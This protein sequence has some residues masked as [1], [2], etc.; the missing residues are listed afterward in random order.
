MAMPFFIGGSGG[1]IAG[2][3]ILQPRSFDGSEASDLPPCAREVWLYLLRNVSHAENGKHKR[4][5]GFFSIG[6]IREALSWHVGYRK[7]YYSKTQ[8]TKSL[9][10]LQKCFMMDST[11]ASRGLHITICNYDIYQD[12]KNY[13]GTNEGIGKNLRRPRG[14]HTKDKN[15]KNDKKSKL[16]LSDSYEIRLSDYLRRWIIKNNPSSKA[17]KADMQK[18]A[19]HVDRMIRV[20]SRTPKEIKAVIKF[21]QTD[22]F[23]LANIL[24]TQKLREK[25]DQLKLREQTTQAPVASMGSSAADET[26]RMLE[27]KEAAL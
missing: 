2:G 17:K 19:V 26:R 22:P 20:D 18:W 7:E 23:W 10:R 25:Y 16:F 13:E 3:Y 11:K 12:P 6:E 21:S 24:S 15:G 9:R 5:T 14:G 1:M 4:G 27:E 8:I